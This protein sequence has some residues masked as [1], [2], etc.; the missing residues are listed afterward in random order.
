MGTSAGYMPP[1]GDNWNSLKRQMGM[2]IDKPEKKELV[3][4]KF[5]TA[6]GGSEK[7]STSNKPI[8]NTSNSRNSA[9]SKSFK[10]S[11]ARKTSQNVL[12]FFS[13]I[14]S[15]GLSQAL[16]DR[17]INLNDKNLEE[18]K[19]TLIDYFTEPSIDGDT[20]A[21]SRAIVTVMD[22]L[23]SEISTEEELENY[24]NNV[25]STEKADKILCGFYENYIFELFARTFFE[26][27]T[28]HSNQSDAVE[29]L[30]IVK[31]TIKSKISTYQCKANLQGIDFKSQDGAN[32][33]QGILNDI[34][35]ILE[36]I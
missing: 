22:D 30:D 7:F 16:Q 26:D 2:L 18:I 32:F 8:S 29:I 27:R 35:E 11:N 5:I 17:N 36:D 9:R 31:E 13:D 25:I 12:G 1:S 21:S 4:S 23:F 33:V 10:S 3:L 6:L 14:N 24:F 34:L 20:D 28:Q 19:E 15:N